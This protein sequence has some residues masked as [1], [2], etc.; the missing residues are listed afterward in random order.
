M[1]LLV[2]GSVGT[3]PVLV[4]LRIGKTPPMRRVVLVIELLVELL[5]L[6]MIIKVAKEALV[7]AWIMGKDQRRG[8]TEDQRSCNDQ[9]SSHSRF[10]G[11]DD[12]GAQH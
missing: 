2:R 1:E 9:R 6:Q 7:L 10:P 5:V 3:V 12:F 11:R 4:L 8:R